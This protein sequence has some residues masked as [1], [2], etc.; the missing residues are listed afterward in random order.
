MDLEL[1][2]GGNHAEYADFARF[3]GIPER[4]GLAERAPAGDVGVHE[5]EDLVGVL[6][7]YDDDLIG[8]NDEEEKVLCS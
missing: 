4:N 8:S 7:A 6:D 2:I 1:R 3:A 5:G